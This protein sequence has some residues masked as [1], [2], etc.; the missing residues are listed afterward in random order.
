MNFHGG[1]HMCESVERWFRKTRAW[2]PW[3]K[4]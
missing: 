2:M 1:K 3:K 4:S